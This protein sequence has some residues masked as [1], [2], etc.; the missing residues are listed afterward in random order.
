MVT[1]TRTGAQSD[2][3]DRQH[4]HHG[5]ADQQQCGA[6]QADALHLG[7]QEWG[8]REAADAGAVQGQADGETAALV[9]ACGEYHGDGGG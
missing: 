6:R 9:K 8:D 4:Q 5:H 3:Q 1:A 7:D 2:H